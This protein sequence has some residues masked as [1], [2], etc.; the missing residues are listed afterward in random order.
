MADHVMLAGLIAAISGLYATAGQAGGTGFVAVMALA[1]FPTDQ[2]RAT[3]LALN[4]VAAGY[5]TARLCF[6][7]SIDWSLL[8]VLIAASLPAAFLGGYIALGG[9]FYSAVTGCL[10]LAACVAMLVKRQ[11]DGGAVSR[12]VAIGI[13]AVTGFASGLSGIGGGVFLAPLL[14]LF[15][16]MPVSRVAGLSPPFI[17]ANSIAGLAGI[18]FAGQRL[19]FG[20]WPLMVAALVG[21]I[22]GTAIGLRWRSEIL[23]RYVLSAVLAVAGA[24]LLI[25]AVAFAP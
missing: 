7:L 15:A 8:G 19:A 24:Q 18:L 2:I 25:R 1:S 17:L 16:R 13:G 9:A 4:V 10:L 11:G 14:V 23:T 22:A 5:A 20:S 12:P 21:S 6:V 3:A